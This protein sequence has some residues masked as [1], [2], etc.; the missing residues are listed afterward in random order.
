VL[1]P[2]RLRDFRLLF[3]GRSLAMV[4]DAVVP[5]ALAIAIVGATGSATA[6][7]IVLACA[8]VP[9]LL[10]LPF[11][12]ILADRFDPR[13]VSIVADLIRCAGQAV[14]G[15]LL[16]L[17]SVDLV[18]IC[19]AQAISGVA[20][21]CAIPTTTALVAGTVQGPARQRANSLM[22]TTRSAAWLL[23][24]G[25]AGLLIFTA[26]AGWVFLVDAATFAAS[27]AL[28]AVIRVT[29]EP[30]RRQSI[31]ADLA[32]GWSEATSRDWYW[33]TLI[34]HGIS[35]FGGS[36][37]L[38][39]G[40]VIAIQQLGGEGTWIAILQAGAIGMLIGSLLA[41]RVRLNRPIL[42]ANIAGA[43]YA[44]PLMMLAIPTSAP[45]LIAGYGFAMAGLGFLNPVWE[46]AVQQRVPAAVL[47]RV[48]AYDWLLSLAAQPL[49]FI[50][51]PVAAS[52][53]GTG[54]PLAIASVLVFAGYVGTALAP[55]VRSLQNSPE[56]LGNPIPV[57]ASR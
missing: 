48:T 15:T 12:G 10:L 35:N 44:I 13:R 7:A 42:A 23:G 29:R 6:L 32:E 26:G 37:L 46:T 57:H 56:P 40:P 27:A 11:G 52:L 2:L 1:N 25:L 49:G 38:T 28:L 54:L 51:A 45:V 21:A 55:G 39:L 31:R 30:V 43:I 53:W 18:E 41:G 4:G 33:T 5:A 19:I 14:V 9:K 16:V 8:L 17:G 47:S 50:L 36:V 20:A 3:I 34:A 24:P 22:A